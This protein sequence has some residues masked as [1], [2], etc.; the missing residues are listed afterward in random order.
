MARLATRRLMK[1]FKRAF[2]ACVTIF[3]QCVVAVICDKSF[4]FLSPC[5]RESRMCLLPAVRNYRLSTG[6]V[7]C[8]RS[9]RRGQY[10]EMGGPDSVRWHVF[11]CCLMLVLQ[12]VVLELY[13]ASGVWPM[14]FCTILHQGAR[15]HTVRRRL[16]SLRL[17]FPKG[18]SYHA[19]QL[20]ALDAQKQPPV[21][22]IIRV[23]SENNV[24]SRW[25]SKYME[26]SKKCTNVAAWL[27][28][29]SCTRYKINVIQMDIYIYILHFLA[30]LCASAMWIVL[31]PLMKFTSKLWHPN[32]YPDGRVCLTRDRCLH[33]VTTSAPRI[34]RPHFYHR[35]PG[36]NNFTSAQ[37]HHVDIK[38]NRLI[39]TLI[40]PPRSQLLRPQTHTH[41]AYTCRCAFRSC[42]NRSVM[43]QEISTRVQQDKTNA[44]VSISA[45]KNAINESIFYLLTGRGPESIWAQLWK[46][47]LVYVCEF[48]VIFTW[49]DWDVTVQS[50]TVQCTGHVFLI[51]IRQWEWV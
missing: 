39:L 9:Y 50:M 7:Y 26:L 16:F 11:V 21:E 18:V 49:R 38:L 15:R 24:L 1:E 46:V 13:L 36:T 34:S 4:R 40:H 31:Q 47:S 8:C 20:I 3:V 41:D 17:E 29:T 42:T 10:S 23:L 45:N 33:I 25:D 6:R 2:L 19:G 22:M 43:A 51:E 44:R 12:H 30:C 28:Q 27:L 35:Y 5:L 48:V 32:I 37:L 14:E